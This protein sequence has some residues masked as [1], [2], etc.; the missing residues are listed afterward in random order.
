[1]STD[2]ASSEESGTDE[3]QSESASDLSADGAA[4]CTPSKDQAEE[5]R[6]NDPLA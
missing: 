3:P 2:H 4:E 6:E 5:N 1:M